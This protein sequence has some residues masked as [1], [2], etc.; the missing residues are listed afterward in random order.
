MD[1]QRYPCL[2]PSGEQDKHKPKGS[3]TAPACPDIPVHEANTAMPGSIV[4]SRRVL[5]LGAVWMTTRS[6]SFACYR[7]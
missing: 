7:L 1:S 3:Q 2:Q 5:L 6:C 4:D